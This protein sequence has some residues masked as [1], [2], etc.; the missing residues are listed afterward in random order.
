MSFLTVSHL[1]SLIVIIC[2]LAVCAPLAAAD[3]PAPAGRSYEVLITTPPSAFEFCTCMVFDANPPACLRFEPT[4]GLF[5]WAFDLQAE[6]G[7]QA[8][9]GVA[10]PSMCGG[11]R[12]GFEG[13]A[14][15]GTVDEVGGDDQPRGPLRAWIP[16]S[17][18]GH[19][20]R[21]LLNRVS[22]GGALATAPG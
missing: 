14:L 15:H 7:V 13:I 4:G 16:E 3:P 9:T 1:K 17:A 21:R 11:P 22:I 2:V 6:D 10:L 12:R 20:D 19:G 18:R 8:T 5:L